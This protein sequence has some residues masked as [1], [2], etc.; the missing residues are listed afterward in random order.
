MSTRLIVRL[1]SAASIALA[2]I[3]SISSSF[4]APIHSTIHCRSRRIMSAIC[5]PTR[6]QQLNPFR[7]H[8]D[9]NSYRRSLTP[10][11]TP[12]HPSYQYS[13]HTPAYHQPDRAPF[14]HNKHNTMGRRVTLTPR[15]KVD[16]AMLPEQYPE[17]PSGSSLTQMDSPIDTRLGKKKTET[18]Y[19][20]RW[21]HCSTRSKT[22]SISDKDIQTGSPQNLFKGPPT[23]PSDLDST[24][25]HAHRGTPRSWKYWGHAIRCT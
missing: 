14:Q 4:N 15:A 16:D 21:E 3:F 25:T 20:W 17:S 9:L 19:G 24:N 22:P 10:S 7:R 13:P 8:S 23:R 12:P 2:F 6:I 18:Q 5:E 1:A 11:N